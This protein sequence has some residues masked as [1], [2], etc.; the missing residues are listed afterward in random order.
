MNTNIC[1]GHKE[2]FALDTAFSGAATN[3]VS[4]GMSFYYC[5]FSYQAWNSLNYMT[6][7]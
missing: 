6:G 4:Y 2:N 7:Q 5:L 3:P 1:S